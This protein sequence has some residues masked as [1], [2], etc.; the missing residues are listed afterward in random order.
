MPEKT[1]KLERPP[2]KVF[3]KL[4]EEEKIK[5]SK[6]IGRR[7]VEGDITEFPEKL[8]KQLETLEY[9]KRPYEV[10]FIN[11][12]NRVLNEI[13]EKCG[14]EPFDI[15]QKNIHM[16]PPEV[17]KK[18]DMPE[19]SSA[20]ADSGRQLIALDASE[21]RFSPLLTATNILHEMTHLKGFIS[22]DVAELGKKDV[23]DS[24]EKQGYRRAVRRVGL[25]MLG[26]YRKSDEGRFYQSFRGLNEA[27]V[28]E[29]EYRHF[30]R[31]LEPSA[32]S[33]EVKNELSRLDSEE[34]LKRKQE[35][36]E[37]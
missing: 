33:L 37:K 14:I 4:Q 13:L 9:E 35:L 36:A 10:N 21:L 29:V 16:V 20:A 18:L 27:L 11:E 8:V 7:F 1:P 28:S 25:K 5:L 32:N 31:V 24:G 19:N 34:V 23:S 2:V 26:S 22:F 12:S 30:M 17:Y 3:G 15:P 6:E